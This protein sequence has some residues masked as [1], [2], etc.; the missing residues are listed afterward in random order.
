[1]HILTVLNSIEHIESAVADL[2]EWFSEVLADEPDAAGLF[3]KMAMQERSHASMVAL[4]KTLARSDPAGFTSID[5]DMDLVDDL[6]HTITEFRALNPRPTVTEALDFAR[7]VESHGAEGIHRS[8]VIQ[9]NPEV[10]D[11]INNLAKADREHFK[12]L[13]EFA[14]TIRV[15]A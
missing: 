5:F 2:Y 1:M 4:S 6:L 8:M 11:M 15:E 3:F 13:E 12:I 9:S 7:K 10:A 14:E